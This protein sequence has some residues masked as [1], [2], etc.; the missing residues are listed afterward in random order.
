[1]LKS[2]D[3]TYLESTATMIQ[4]KLD[5]WWQQSTTTCIFKNL[6]YVQWYLG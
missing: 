4:Q 6:S 1:M 5:K 3:I 2:I